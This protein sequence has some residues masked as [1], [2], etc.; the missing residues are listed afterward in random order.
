[1]N[2][3]HLQGKTAYVVGLGR[4]G[5]TTIKALKKAVVK[6]YAWDDASSNRAT[7]QD[8][9]INLIPPEELDYT[10]IDFLVISPGIPN[11]HPFPHPAAAKARKEG[12]PLICDIELFAQGITHMPI[13][14]QPKIIGITGT[15]G[16]STV[17]AMMTHILS[18]LGYKAYAGGNIGNAVFSLP[19][20][21][22]DQFYILEL[23]SY[24]L[25]LIETPFL[26]ATLLINISED[27]LER[28]GGMKG[29]INAKERIFRLGKSGGKNIIGVDDAYT[30]EIFDHYKNM[31]T[32]FSETKQIDDMVHVS[33]DTLINPR[34]QEILNLNKAS[35][36]KGVHNH[37][38]IAACYTVLSRLLDLSME[39]FGDALSGFKGLPHRQEFITRTSGITFINDSK[40]TSLEAAAKS[41]ENYQNIYW[42]M[43]GQ[44]KSN[45]DKISIIAPY[46]DNIRQAYTFGESGDQYAKLL[47]KDIPAKYFETLAA[48]AEAAFIDASSDSDESV[49][50]LSPACSS[51]D[52]FKDFEDRGNQ[53]KKQIK[54]LTGA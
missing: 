10:L 18:A 26:S 37:Q 48:A 29:Y 12:V 21:L 1:M 51:F 31:L 34:T 42:I 35:I 33:N 5:M 25:E 9:D 23:S 40:A 47:A 49:V 15:N 52:Q 11:L 38:N 54:N 3:D 30:S 41:L 22:A 2:L 19:D 24:Q 36:L 13:N 46:F 43:G 45:W 7:V 14:Q 32:G 27:H 8:F 28:H 16:K 4:S 53:F 6:I 39:D 17:T 50:L 44:A 20:I